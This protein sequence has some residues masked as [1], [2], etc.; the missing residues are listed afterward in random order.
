MASGAPNLF[1]IIDPIV[2]GTA[3]SQVFTVTSNTS[4]PNGWSVIRW[5]ITPENG[6]D[7]VVI[8]TPTITKSVTGTGP[9]TA[10]LTCPFSASDSTSMLGGSVLDFIRCTYELSYEGSSTADIGVIESGTVEVFQPRAT[11]PS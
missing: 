8:T 5:T 7:P 6:A 10:T 9:W 1:Q 4:D 3:A 2:A 11:L